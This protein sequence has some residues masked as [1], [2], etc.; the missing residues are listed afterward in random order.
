MRR[1]LRLKND[2]AMAMAKHLL[3]IVQN[4]I[5]PSEH[6]DAFG[7][8]FNVCLAGLETY[9]QLMDQLDKRLNPSQN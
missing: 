6:Q 2:T 7:E 8:F 5:H 1:N 4:A 3:E 9:E